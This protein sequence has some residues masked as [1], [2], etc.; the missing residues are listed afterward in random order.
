MTKLLLW[1]INACFMLN[2]HLLMKLVT[3]SLK[4]RLSNVTFSTHHFIFTY[5]NITNELLAISS[6]ISNAVTQQNV[7]VHISINLLEKIL[8]Y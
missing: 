2:K 1:T 4:M 8:I 7:L 5:E 3:S 6:P